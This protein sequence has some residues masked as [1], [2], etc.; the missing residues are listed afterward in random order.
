MVS[1]AR[2][3]KRRVLVV[4]DETDIRDMLAYNLRQEG[5]D[6][7]SRRHRRQPP[8]TRSNQFGPD[9]VILDLMLPDISGVEVCRRIRGRDRSPS[10]RS[11]C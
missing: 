2:S 10:R 4:E 8:W 7:A 1:P 11:S 6:V 9:L 3:G 5:Y